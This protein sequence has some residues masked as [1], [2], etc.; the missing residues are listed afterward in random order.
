MVNEISCGVCR[1]LIPLVKDAVAGEE[2]RLAV[3]RHT[4]GCPA[5]RAL[6]GAGAPPVPDVERAW[7]RLARRMRLGAA[8][9][10][11]FGV[12][13]GLS[14]TA[15][16]DMFYNVMIMPLTGALGYAVFRWRALYVL[17]GLLAAAHLAVNLLSRLN[18]GEALDLWSLLFWTG[19]YCLLAVAGVLSAGL[20]H[21]AFRKEEGP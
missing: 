10:M 15:G 1:D 3:E 5:C 17:P 20:L 6:Y 2:S 11:T 16:T 13:F 7:T 8:I 18:G 9:L 19:I 12:F 21:F 14:L 4:A